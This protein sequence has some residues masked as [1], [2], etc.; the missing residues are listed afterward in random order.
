[1]NATLSGLFEAVGLFML[2]IQHLLFKG[3]CYPDHPKHNLNWYH[4]KVVLH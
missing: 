4:F 1:M 2:A 3:M